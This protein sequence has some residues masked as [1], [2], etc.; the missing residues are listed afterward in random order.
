MD[1]ARSGGRAF[2]VL[3]TLIEASGAVVSKDE[4]LSCV[5]EERIVDENRLSGRA[6]RSVS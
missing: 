1:S 5:W 2:D 6:G 3:M 4:L